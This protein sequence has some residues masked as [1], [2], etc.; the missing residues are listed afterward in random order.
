MPDNLP[1]V[2]LTASIACPCEEA[3][4]DHITIEG[5][6]IPR[7]LLLA[8]YTPRENLRTPSI[9]LLE[10][11]DANLFFTGEKA[12]DVRRQ[13]AAAKVFVYVVLHSIQS[14]HT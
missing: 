12:D 6:Q 1:I 2:A 3:T 11:G 9:L 14:I 4:E 7:D 5:C 13:L 10:W 8:T